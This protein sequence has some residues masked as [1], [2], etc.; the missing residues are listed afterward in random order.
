MSTLGRVWPGVFGEGNT[1]TAVVLSS[2]G[3]WIFYFLILRGVEGATV[4]N[5]IVTVAKIVPILTFIVIVIFA[6]KVHVFSENFW[7]GEP[8]TA[9]ALFGQVRATML[10]TVLIFLGIEGASV[11]SRY[12]KRREDVGRATVLGF[13]SVLTLFVSVTMLSFGIL[14]RAGLEKLRQPSMAGVLESVVGYWGV[15]FI[16]VGVTVSVLGAYLAWT[17]M[18]AEVLYVA[19]KDKDMPS[20]LRPNQRQGRPRP[21]GADDHN[22]HSGRAADHAVLRRC[23]HVHAQAVQLAVAD[24]VPASGRV[25]AEARGSWRDLRRAAAAQDQGGARRGPGHLLRRVPNFAAGLDFALLSFIIYA[26]GTILFVMSRREQNRRP[27]SPGEMVI[28]VIA[29]AGAVAGIIALATGTI[30]I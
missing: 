5:K 17:L 28:L 23:V 3:I 8:K 1:I 4:I 15:A 29:V 25:R 7:G 26:P 30:T 11:Y 14:P 13:L 18:S 6:L 22:S 24:P 20:F 10:V 21:R 27:F 12:A 16:S 9:S 2:V 19:A